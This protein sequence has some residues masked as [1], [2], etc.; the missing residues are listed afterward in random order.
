MVIHK[1]EIRLKKKN[2]EEIISTSPTF[3]WL[4]LLL[5]LNNQFVNSVKVG[6][7]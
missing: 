3:K 7:K 4:L 1:T 2:G 5:I 6:P